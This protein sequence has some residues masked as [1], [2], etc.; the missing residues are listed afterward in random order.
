ML[1]KDMGRRDFLKWSGIAGGAAMITPSLLVGCSPKEVEPQEAEKDTSGYIMDA[2]SDGLPYGADK[3]CPVICGTGDACGQSHTCQ[4]Y[5]KDGTIVYYEGCTEG[6]NG[7]RMCARGQSGF[8]IVNSPDRIKYPMRRTNEKGVVGE[9]ERIGWEEA[10]E[11]I[12][13]A[14]AQAIEEEGPHTVATSWA[15]NTSFQMYSLTSAFNAIF[16]T[17]A[18]ILPDCW[19][20]LQFGPVPTLGDMFHCHME[21]ALESKLIILWGENTSITKPQEWADSYGAAKYKGGAKLVV[22]DSRLTE[23]ALKADVYIPVRPGTDAYVAL[24]MANVIIEENLVDQAF[25]DEHTYGYEEFK[26]LAVKYTPEDVEKITWAPADKVRELAREYATAKPSMIAIGRGGNSAGGKRS[27]AGWMMSRAIC[28]LPGLCGQF[29]VKGAGVSIET[30]SGSPSK[31]CYHW[32]APVVMAGSTPYVTPRI[33]GTSAHH[34]GIWGQRDVLYYRD[35]YGYRVMVGNGNFAASSGNQAEADAAFKAIGMTVIINRTVHFTASRYADI[36]LPTTCWPEQHMFRSDWTE[37]VMT[38]PAVEPMFE[39]KCDHD[40]Y[41]E[42]ALALAK[43][44]GIEGSDKEI[45][46]WES[47]ID[48]LRCFL[49]GDAAKAAYAQCV[50][51]GLEEYEGMAEAAVEDIETRPAG[52]PNPFFAGQK[53]FVPYKAKHYDYAGGVPEGIDPESVWF[54][55]D[56]GNGRLLFKADFLPQCSGDVLPAMPIPEEPEDSYYVDGNPIES[57]NWEFSDAVKNGYEYVAVGRGHSPW[58]FLSFH[59]NPDGGPASQ[60]LREAFG[61]ACEPCVGINPQD[62][63]KLGIEQDD[64]VTIESQYGKIESVKANLTERIMPSTIFPPYHWGTVQNQIYPSSRTLEAVDAKLRP[65]VTPPFVGQFNSGTTRR[66]SAGIN[67]QTG[68]LC[69]VYKA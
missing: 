13:E 27:N 69:K 42:I 9:F 59:Q 7:G 54:P 3:V 61:D 43:K 68:T 31:L 55:T 63:A 17:E 37:A 39:C 2:V 15:H 49:T 16:G 12:T 8:D 52:V 33:K 51:A 25:I 65:Q 23:T 40:I 1:E 50:E 41:R 38:P 20:D 24:A 47:E 14:M 21:D 5:V 67:C 6:Y 60:L 44:L 46:P 48:Y 36:L 28:C 19:F 30:S 56:G 11:E 10:I 53:G 62:A 18:A 57:G 22:I 35:P 64:L 29:G 66:S 34:G 32:P 45:W 4:C 58:Q 26:A